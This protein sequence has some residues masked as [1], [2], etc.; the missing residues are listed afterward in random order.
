LRDIPHDL[1]CEIIEAGIVL[2]GGGALLP[3]MRERLQRA[4]AI[5]VTVPR[6]PLDTVIKGLTHM[7]DLGTVR[8]R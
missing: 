6:D 7:L 2:T 5:S 4:T 1:G 3:G 8:R